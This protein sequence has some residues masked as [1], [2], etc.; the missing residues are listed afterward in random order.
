MTCHPR[1]FSDML[2]DRTTSK[3]NQH[4]TTMTVGK[5]G[6]GKSNMNLAVGYAYACKVAN[7]MGGEWQDYFNLDNIGIITR[8]EIYRVMMIEKKYSYLMLDDIGVGWNARKW[9]DDFNN[10]LND[11]LQTFRTDNT[12]LAVTLPDS[13]LIDKVPRSMVH[14]FIEMDMP[15][16]DKGMTIAK[17]FETVRKPRQGKTYFQYPRGETKFVRYAFPLAPKEI[18][19]PYEEKRRQISKDLKSERLEDFRVKMEAM[20]ETE[21]DKVPKFSKKERVV[22][23]IRDVNVGVYPSF[24]AAITAHN[25]EFPKWRISHGYAS[26]VRAGMA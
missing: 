13:F 16:F 19:E 5:T 15:L 26:N 2:V 11:I 7:K 18:T 4:V 23:L 20:H 9:Q 3:Y 6:S 25:K 8:E 21:E 24:K 14:F 10:I 12:A 1:S 17:I 22:E